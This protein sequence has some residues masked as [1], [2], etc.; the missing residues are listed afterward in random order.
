MRNMPFLMIFVFSLMFLSGC[1]KTPAN[2]VDEAAKIEGNMIL[3]SPRMSQKIKT[4]VPSTKVANNDLT[5]LGKVDFDPDLV[6]QVYSL[7]NGYIARI[8]VTVGDRVRR[9]EVLAEVHSSDYASAVSD[10]QKANSI[11]NMAKENL[12]RTRRLYSDKIVSEREMESVQNDYETAKAEYDRAVKALAL[13]GGDPDVSTPVYR[14]TSPIYG[15]VLERSAEPGSEV[16][17]DG[18]P[19][20][21]VGDTKRVWISLSLYQD[22]IPYVS[23]GDSVTISVPGVDTLKLKTRIAYVS[24]TIDENTMAAYARCLVNNPSGML[25]PNMYCTGIV[26]HPGGHVITLP[27]NSV[28]YG[29]DG[30]TYVFVQKGPNTFERRLVKV[31]TMSNDEDVI[32]SGILLTDRVVLDEALFLNEEFTNGLK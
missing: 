11:L 26:H 7:V 20:F 21:V 4:G 13:L 1:T 16:R 14:I 22:Q 30:E 18:R 32:G 31:L 23:K 3:L 10:V 19:L 5:L 24:S 29:A 25:K 2:L 17:S 12:D 28:V 6:S 15:Y 27:A 8:Y 9:G